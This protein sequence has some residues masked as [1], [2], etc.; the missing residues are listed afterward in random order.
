MQV[1]GSSL[2]RSA[3]VA[4]STMLPVMA[5]SGLNNDNQARAVEQ[6]EEGQLRTQGFLINFKDDFLLRDIKKSLG[7]LQ[8]EK[9]QVFNRSKNEYYISVK[10]KLLWKDLA[11]VIKDANGV[12]RVGTPPINPNLPDITDEFNSIGKV[13][14]PKYINPKNSTSKI[15]IQSGSAL[16]VQTN[17]YAVVPAFLGGTLKVRLEG[18]RSLRHFNSEDGTSFFVGSTN[19]GKIGNFIPSTLFLAETSGLTKLTV[20]FYDKEGKE[21]EKTTY[22]IEV[23]G[24]K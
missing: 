4:V 3:V 10:S 2:V 14:E 15:Q 9:V 13:H 22:N 23:T 12:E 20:T 24:K 7:E 1:F 6:R 11:N 19:D 21:R 18:D 16:I 5:V 8:V 17:R